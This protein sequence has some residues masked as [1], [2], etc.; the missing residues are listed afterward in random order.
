MYG[1]EVMQPKEDAMQMLAG[2]M[3]AQ[4]EVLTAALEKAAGG[5]KSG[6]LGCTIRINPTVKWPTLSDEGADSR[7]IEG[8]FD[9]FDE[10]AQLA[11]DGR[12]MATLEPLRVL[13]NCLV[14]GRQSVYSRHETTYCG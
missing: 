3:K 13:Q 6:Q 10:V 1:E 11:N 12:G 8:F 9:R 2:A 4:T 14:G 5:S 7:D